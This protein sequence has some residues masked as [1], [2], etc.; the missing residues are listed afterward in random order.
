MQLKNERIGTR[1]RMNA[2]AGGRS[3]NEAFVTPWDV[4]FNV[5]YPPLEV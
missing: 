3:T 5:A 2:M 1:L 4:C